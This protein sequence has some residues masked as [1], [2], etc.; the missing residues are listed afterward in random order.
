MD[1][2]MFSGFFFRKKD[3]KKKEMEGIIWAAT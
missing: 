3:F 2:D 1:L